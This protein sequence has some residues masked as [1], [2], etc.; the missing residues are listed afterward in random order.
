MGKKTGSGSVMND[1]GHI[2]ESLEKR[3]LNL[4]SLMRIR[5]GKNTDPGGRKLYSGIRV[6]H[7]E[8]VTLEPGSGTFL[9][10]TG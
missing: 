1:Q 9:A 10:P 7:P 4:N 2:T 6:K 5:D 3:F 8:S